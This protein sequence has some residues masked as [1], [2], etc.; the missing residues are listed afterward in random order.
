MRYAEH[1][2]NQ[3]RTLINLNFLTNM[4]TQVQKLISFLA[5]GEWHHSINLNNHMGWKWGA[6]LADARD[7][8]KHGYAVEDRRDPNEPKYKYYR[9]IHIPED[10]AT[11]MNLSIVQQFNQKMSAKLEKENYEQ[12]HPTLL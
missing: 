5:D 9:L 8:R 10:T 1:V 6:R 4:Q 7:P 3:C 2:A 12:R 11:E